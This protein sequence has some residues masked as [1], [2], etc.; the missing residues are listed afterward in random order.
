VAL[1]TP[2]PT[3]EPSFEGFVQQHA[4]RFGGYLRGVLGA[5]AEGRGGRV[6]LEDTLQDAFLRMYEAW[7]E[8]QDVH[9]DERD[10]RLY[11]YLRD[12]AGRALRAEHG[13]LDRKTERVRLV[14]FDFDSIGVGEYDELPRREREV[15]ASV[16]GAM[17]RD[18][19]G[20][21]KAIRAV[22][23]RGIL[24][25]GLRA[26]TE[27]EAVLLLS[28]DYLRWDQQALANQLGIKL[29]ALEKRL[30]VARKIFYSVVRHASEIEVDDEERGRLADYLSGQLEGREKRI[31]RRHLQHC[32][33]C[34]ALA[35][36][37][38]TFNRAAFGLLAPLPFLSAASAKL[39]SREAVVKAPA[40]GGAGVAAAA[41][42]GATK[43]LAVVGSVLAVGAGF[44]AFLGRD[45]D[46]HP[47][48]VG[49]AT[50]GPTSPITY[51]PPPSGMKR[52]ASKTGTAAVPKKPST[53]KRKS[54]AKRRRKAA[55]TSSSSHA[56]SS[57]ASPSTTQ[58]S[59]STSSAGS[60]SSSSSAAGSASPGAS[61]GAQQ[62]GSKSNNNGGGYFGT[63][64]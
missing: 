23:D 29:D 32:P 19:A 7:P 59:P 4:D 49:P 17:V 1:T 2:D 61:S 63:G 47:G 52:P 51:T 50:T 18:C 58:G 16:L 41:P 10:R 40:V 25:A 38:D 22:L 42:A 46:V 28:V 62:N 6:P 53:A 48:E 3:G 20:G 43:A 26:L 30:Y 56:P 12:A 14:P 36:E 45:A 60:S 9:D 5:Q 64:P 15:A 8:L 37:T 44:V 55:G 54:S 35:R 21:D 11:R 13:R 57:A 33:T 27:Q 34:Q 31:A 24:L 39:L